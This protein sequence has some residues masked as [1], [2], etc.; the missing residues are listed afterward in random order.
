MAG[1]DPLISKL[2]HPTPE[3]LL[4]LQEIRSN[5][6]KTVVRFLYKGFKRPQ[7]ACGS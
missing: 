2:L 7:L 4:I 3:V 1:V 5:H 6:L